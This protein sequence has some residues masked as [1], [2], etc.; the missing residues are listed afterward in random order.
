MSA[1]YAAALAAVDRA[2]NA[3]GDATIEDY[4]AV[5]AQVAT[6]RAVLALVDEVEPLVELLRALVERGTTDEQRDLDRAR[7][8]AQV[9]SCTGTVGCSGPVHIRGCPGDACGVCTQPFEPDDKVTSVDGRRVH[10]ACDPRTP[11]PD[12]RYPPMRTS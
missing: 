4:P 6:A 5:L 12:P 9:H 7:V 3:S 2:D 8:T 1:A 10:R 11:P